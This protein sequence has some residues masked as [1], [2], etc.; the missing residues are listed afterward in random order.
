MRWVSNRSAKLR[1]LLCRVV[2][3][4]LSHRHRVQANRDRLWPEIVEHLEGAGKTKGEPE[5]AFYASWV[6]S[7][8]QQAIEPHPDAAPPPQPSVVRGRGPVAPAST[9]HDP[10]TIAVRSDRFPD[11]VRTC[12][13]NRRL[14]SLIP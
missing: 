7:V 8:I 5:D 11:I 2:R 13:E 12:C 10:V 6:E 14:G 1:T 9:L 4:I 3:N